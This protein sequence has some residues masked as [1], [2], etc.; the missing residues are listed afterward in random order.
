MGKLLFSSGE[1]CLHVTCGRRKVGKVPIAKCEVYGNVSTVLQVWVVDVC[2]GCVR[3]WKDFNRFGISSD[4]A[5]AELGQLSACGDSEPGNWNEGIS[6]VLLLAI[7]MAVKRGFFSPKNYEFLTIFA[8]EHRHWKWEKRIFL[9]VNSKNYVFSFE[10]RSNEIILRI[11]K[12]ISP[13]ML[14]TLA[15]NAVTV[16]ATNRHNDNNGPNAI[17]RPA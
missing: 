10:F 15:Y 6:S 4:E 9:F 13:K 17:V 1:A 14:F 12:K 5:Q 7:M 8:A 16:A 2:V 11:S 3:I